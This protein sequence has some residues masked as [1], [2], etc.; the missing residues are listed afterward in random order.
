M[1]TTRTMPAVAPSLTE[2]ERSAVAV[3]LSWPSQPGNSASEGVAGQGR[4]LHII[5][6]IGDIDVR[7]AAETRDILT[8]LAAQGADFTV[9]VSQVR[10]IDAS[11]LGVLAAL[12]R[13]VRESGGQCSLIGAAPSLRRILHI[14]Q[15]TY[16]LAG[17]P[18]CH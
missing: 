4:G 14:T 3:T 6:L 2:D 15:L 5:E 13:R 11:G 7:L 1:T 12:Y 9:D 16:L 10:F 18:S 8:S 17:E